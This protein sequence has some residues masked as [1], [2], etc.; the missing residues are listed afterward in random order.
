MW[1]KL[2]HVYEARLRCKNHISAEKSRQLGETFREH[3]PL[4]RKRFP[5]W[6]HLSKKTTI[7]WSNEIKKSP[8]SAS[9]R[10]TNFCVGEAYR[11]YIIE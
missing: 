1:T 10:Q 11:A 6:E 7:I 8:F 2:V 3:L 5:S 9:R 4:M